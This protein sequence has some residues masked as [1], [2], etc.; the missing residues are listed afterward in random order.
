[1]GLYDALRE[2][3]VRVPDHLS[4]VGFDNQEVIAA[5]LHP[6][7][8]TVALP[9]YDLGVLGVRML[10]EPSSD[11]KHSKDA[12]SAPA[13]RPGPKDLQEYQ[14]VHVSCPSVVRRSIAVPA[15]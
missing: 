15:R 14:P 5:H 4:V 10:L 12:D 6:G 13:V 9:Q 2:R 3:G 1:M 11:R 7:L 8:T